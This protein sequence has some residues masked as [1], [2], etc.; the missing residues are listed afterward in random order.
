MATAAVAS[1]L[2]AECEASSG[3][4]ALS[5]DLQV[6][7]T[8]TTTTTSNSDN[9]NNDTNNTRANTA[10]TTTSAPVT[11]P[12]TNNTNNTISTTTTTSSIPSRFSALIPTP[13]TF[14][15]AG[16]L[17][18]RRLIQSKDAT[19][20]FLYR[21][22]SPTYRVCHLYKDS[23]TN[24]SQL[25]SLERIKNSFVRG[26]AIT[27]IKSSTAQMKD[28]WGQ[29]MAA[30]SAKAAAAHA[31]TAQ[32]ERAKLIQANRAMIEEVNKNKKL[33]ESSDRRGGSGNDDGNDSS[34]SPGGIGG[35]GGLE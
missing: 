34:S 26:D 7:D 1:H 19:T 2:A 17:V 32:A 23:F 3:S 6:S 30:Y 16:S 14:Q 22:F 20:S 18:H 9:L 33:Q 31:K 11:S 13:A 24:G 21:T 12:S 35:M 28:V 10:A 27:L 5:S 15:S 4:A 25:R 29:V 8:T